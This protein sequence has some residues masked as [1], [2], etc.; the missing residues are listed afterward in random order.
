VP[1][2]D[3][4]HSGQTSTSKTTENF[5]KIRELIQEDCRRTIYELA[6]TAGISYLWSLPQNL[7]RKLEHVPHC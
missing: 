5:E 2:E 6:D 4:K 7:N 1:V 3:N